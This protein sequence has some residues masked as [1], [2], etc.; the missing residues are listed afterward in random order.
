EVV[1]DS[2]RVEWLCEWVASMRIQCESGTGKELLARDI[3][4]RIRRVQGPFVSINCGAIPRDLLESNLFGHVKGSFTG[5][6][7]DAAGLFRVAGGGTF[8]LDEIGEMPHATQVKL[9][10]ARQEREL[11]PGVGPQ[12][13]RL[14]CRRVG[15]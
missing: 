11:I 12:P 5:A 3:H 2:E 9:L 7:R 4:Y 8:F 10:R 13:I 1:V 14:V 6:V 15:G